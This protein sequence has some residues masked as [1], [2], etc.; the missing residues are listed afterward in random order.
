[1]Y[2]TTINSISIILMIM[3]SIINTVVIERPV[4]KPVDTIN[5]NKLLHILIVIFIIEIT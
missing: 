5:K 1:M 4:T 2:V 3:D